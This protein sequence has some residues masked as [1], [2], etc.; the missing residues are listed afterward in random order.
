M[1]H[2]FLITGCVILAIMVI[3]SAHAGTFKD[4]RPYMSALMVLFA[5][6]ADKLV[7]K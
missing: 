3:G 5:I 1:K 6:T 4:A 2:M 7:N